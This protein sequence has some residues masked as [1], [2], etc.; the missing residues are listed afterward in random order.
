MAGVLPEAL[1]TQCVKCNERQKGGA[2]K[3][4]KHLI[5]HEPELYNELEKKFDPTGEYRKQ[6]DAVLGKD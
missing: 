1:Q 3:M 2:K 4:L 6:Y 5:D